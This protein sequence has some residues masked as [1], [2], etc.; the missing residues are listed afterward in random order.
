[1]H[2]ADSHVV[3]PLAPVVVDLDRVEAAVLVDE[4]EHVGRGLLGEQ[5]VPEIDDDADVVAPD[6]LNAE[7]RARGGREGQVGARL[8]E[9]VLDRHTHTGVHFGDAAH[10]VELESPELGV[11][12]LEGVVEAV[13]ARPQLHGRGAEL[14]GD[15]DALLADPEG[16]AAHRGIGVGE[17][18]A[19]EL[20]HVDVRRDAPGLEA[21]GVERLLDLVDRDVRVRERIVDVE[22]LERADL[23]CAGDRLECADL[24]PVGVCCVAVDKLPEQPDTGSK[25]HALPLVC[26]IIH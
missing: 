11:V 12:G 22:H 16:A 15:V 20:A 7:Q 2:G 4:L 5:R 10:A 13:L 24:G 21:R 25:P 9:L 6:R 26:I 1:V 17:R 3:V 8:L 19:G 23:A 18:A 14:L